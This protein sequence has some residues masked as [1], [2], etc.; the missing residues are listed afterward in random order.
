MSDKKEVWARFTE[1]IPERAHR[2]RCTL[3]RKAWWRATKKS[4]PPHPATIKRLVAHY[5][6][7]EDYVIHGR[8]PYAALGILSP[9]QASSIYTRTS[10]PHERRRIFHRIA[11][12]LHDD[13]LTLF[14]D[15]TFVVDSSTQAYSEVPM[16]ARDSYK[17]TYTALP[18]RIVLSM[19]HA[20]GLVSQNMQFG[21]EPLSSLDTFTDLVAHAKK[22]KAQ[23]QGASAFDRFRKQSEKFMSCQT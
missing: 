11:L 14:S 8:L 15:A 10:D 22:M 17:I 21:L 7:D 6:L 20:I 3:E 2:E 19:H 18:E 1:V 9:E 13:L 12:Q 4:K 23:K 16:S 5:K